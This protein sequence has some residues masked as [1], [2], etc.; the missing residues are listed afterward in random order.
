MPTHFFPNRTSPSS[1]IPIRRSP[2]FKRMLQPTHSTSFQ[3]NAAHVPQTS[4]SQFEFK[5]SSPHSIEESQ[6]STEGSHHSAEG[7]QHSSDSQ[8]SRTRRQNRRSSRDGG[9]SVRFDLPSSPDESSH[10][11]YS[12]LPGEEGKDRLESA[13]DGQTKDQPQRNTPVAIA[14]RCRSSVLL[15]MLSIIL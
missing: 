15:V 9:R 6:P 7:S 14:F 3:N 10:S 8:H 13:P 12:L 4:T 1:S 2:S 11:G 5:D